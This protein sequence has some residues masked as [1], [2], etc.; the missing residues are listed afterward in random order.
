MWCNSQ[1]MVRVISRVLQRKSRSHSQVLW[2]EE[3]LC[4]LLSMQGMSVAVAI[5][6]S[7]VLRDCK[8][9]FYMVMSASNFLS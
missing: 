4:R 7:K 5:D 3:R 2:Y 9:R 6:P 8:N 1:H